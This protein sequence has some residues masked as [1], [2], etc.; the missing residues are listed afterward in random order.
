MGEKRDDGG[1]GGEG[2]VGGEASAARGTPDGFASAPAGAEEGE[3]RKKAV[4]SE[5][6]EG[7]GHRDA[8]DGDGLVTRG[9]GDDDGGAAVP[10][11]EAPDTAFDVDDV[12]GEETEVAFFGLLDASGFVRTGGSALLGR[13]SVA[14]DGDHRAK[15][16]KEG[17]AIAPEISGLLEGEKFIAIRFGEKVEVDRIKVVSIDE[18]DKG[19][20][21]RGFGKEGGEAEDGE[22]GV[23]VGISGDDKA[24]IGGAS[25][26][27]VAPSA[28]GDAFAPGF[29]AVVIH[30]EGAEDRGRAEGAFDRLEALGG[31]G[32]SDLGVIG[33]EEGDIVEKKSHK[34]ESI[35]VSRTSI[36]QRKPRDAPGSSGGR[37]P[38]VTRVTEPG[39]SECEPP[40]MTRN[41]P[42]GAPVGLRSGIWR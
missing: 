19:F 15:G 41:C 9:E 20:G 22:G 29:G 18:R 28:E 3:D 13:E 39:R 40:R 17:I 2:I 12:R 35:S 10:T 27:M 7:A 36:A 33:V 31:F 5:E 34:A 26:V 1:S 24:G 23:S 21:D 8:T 4:G 16:A 32:R 6:F 42:R 11:I 38:R 25:G 37:K 14:E 30:R